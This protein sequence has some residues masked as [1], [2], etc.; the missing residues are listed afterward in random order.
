MV[1]LKS[2]PPLPIQ[3]N[4][5]A[6]LTVVTGLK[7]GGEKTGLGRPRGPPLGGPGPPVP[8]QPVVL[9]PPTPPDLRGGGVPLFRRGYLR[10]GGGRALISI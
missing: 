3:T 4:P 5:P 9:M 6:S 10:R 8:P 2:K 7:N 1:I